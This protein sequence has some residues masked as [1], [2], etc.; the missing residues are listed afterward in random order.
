MTSL[1]VDVDLPRTFAP[2]N[3]ARHGV[4]SENPLG[5]LEDA[6]TNQQLVKDYCYWFWNYR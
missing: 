1:I 6:K 5:E 2:V 3:M 4:V